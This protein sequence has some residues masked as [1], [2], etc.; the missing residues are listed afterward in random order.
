MSDALLRE[1]A[2]RGVVRGN[3]LYLRPADALDLLQRYDAAG[4]TVIGAEAAMLAGGRTYPRVDGIADFS[5]GCAATGD[6]LRRA[7]TAECAA[8]LRE[9]P[10]EADL[11][12]TLVALD[13]AREPSN[14]GHT[15]LKG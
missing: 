9:L 2:S 5:H 15:G 6:D 13:D 14:K 1:F 10:D 3:E 11:F 12:V 4:I 7:C 8:F